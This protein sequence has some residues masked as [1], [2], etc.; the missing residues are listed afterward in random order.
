MEKEKFKT[1]NQKL[2]IG[3]GVG[4]SKS[5]KVTQIT[6]K[7]S[8]LKPRIQLGLPLSKDKSLVY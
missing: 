5:G 1:G 2:A 4:P 8:F 6:R 7:E 3:V